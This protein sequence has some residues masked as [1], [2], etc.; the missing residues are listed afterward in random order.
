[1]HAADLRSAA[2]MLKQVP[3][4]PIPGSSPSIISLSVTRLRQTNSN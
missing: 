1:M 2:T 4:L 3:H